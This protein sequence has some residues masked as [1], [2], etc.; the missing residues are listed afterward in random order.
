MAIHLTKG[1]RNKPE[2]SDSLG[3]HVNATHSGNWILLAIGKYSVGIDVEEIKPDFAF[4]EMIPISF[5]AQEQEYI[6]ADGKSTV[7][8][9]ELWTRKE[10]IV[11]A[12]GRGIDEAFSQ[13]PAL[14]GTHTW[15]TTL[16][17]AAQDWII[18]SFHV[19]EE[20]PAAIAYNRYPKNIRFY[21]LDHGI[22]PS[23]DRR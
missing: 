17:E 3:W 7:R 13:V 19:A 9:Y 6:E 10:A 12:I 8:F 23:P 20:Y 16:L 11:K 21:T 18:D 14:T 22:F 1:L 5:S 2:L 15:K 4:T